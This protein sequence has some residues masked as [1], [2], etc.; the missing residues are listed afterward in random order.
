M[1]IYNYPVPFFS[2]IEYKQSS[3]LFLLLFCL[4]VYIE[5]RLRSS[6]SDFIT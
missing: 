6:F 2:L 3:D 1:D 5:M 4:I